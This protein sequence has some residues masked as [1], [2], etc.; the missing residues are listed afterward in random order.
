MNLSCYL[1]KTMAP[2]WVDGSLPG[3]SALKYHVNACLNCQSEIDKYRFILTELE[4]FRGI[5]K[6][7]NI[8]TLI[9]NKNEKN[10]RLDLLSN[11]A[12]LA[13]SFSLSGATVAGLV[14]YLLKRRRV[15]VML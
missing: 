15:G 4:N 8:S 2:S 11:K 3:F 7:Q 10:A 9:T 5:K 12:F 1:V 13:A 14:T 6:I